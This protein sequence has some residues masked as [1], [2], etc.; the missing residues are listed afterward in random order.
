MIA[1]PTVFFFGG[2]DG[3]FLILL[4]GILL[5]IWE[6]IT[7]DSPWPFEASSLDSHDPDWPL[8]LWEY[9]FVVHRF[10]AVEQ[11]KSAKLLYI[12][13]IKLILTR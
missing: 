11:K 12:F 5:G 3:G 7:D 10:I 13:H 1:K 4:G 9:T 8:D 2:G 6:S